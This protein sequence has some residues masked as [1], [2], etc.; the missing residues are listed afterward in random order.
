MANDAPAKAFPAPCFDSVLGKKESANTK[1]LVR[2]H[3]ACFPTCTIQQQKL[4]FS[5]W[6][7]SRD[8]SSPG[9]PREQLSSQ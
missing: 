9:Y 7:L 8:C 3:Q 1:A 5:C 4:F 2:W 6:K